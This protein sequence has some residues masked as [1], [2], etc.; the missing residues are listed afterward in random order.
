[1]TKKL[2]ILMSAAAAVAL[3]TPAA[4]AEGSDGAKV[5]IDQVQLHEVWSNL[6]VQFGDKAHGD[7][8]VGTSSVG[9][10]APALIKSGY[11]TYSAKQETYGDTG[12]VTDVS[13]GDIK[14]GLY[15]SITSYDNASTAGT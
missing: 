3:I 7:I 15:A 1:M 6:D 11:I 12:A 2:N 5:Y 10:T 4:L 9:N 8:A 13:G 14:G